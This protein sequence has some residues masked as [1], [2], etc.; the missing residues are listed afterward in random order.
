MATEVG[1]NLPPDLVAAL[2]DPAFENLAV[3]LL[4]TDRHGYPHVALLSTL[5]FALYRKDRLA[6]FVHPGSRTAVFL[7]RNK[8]CTLVF[9]GES[10]VYYVKGNASFTAL[11]GGVV[12]FLFS[13]HMTLQDHPSESEQDTY[14]S[15][16]LRFKAPP[17]EMERRRALRGN[18][19]AQLN[20]LLPSEKHS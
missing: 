5:E 15:S 14:L 11:V 18:V 20:A 16:G 17:S 9:A 3:P 4:T 12:V 13:V 1:S 19:V 10:F 2:Q 7:Q 6:F 8:I